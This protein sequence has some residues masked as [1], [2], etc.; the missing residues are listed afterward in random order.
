M[1]NPGLDE[2]QAEIKITRKISVTSDMHTTLMAESKG[3]KSLLMNVK[4]ESGK[5][6]LNS[7]SEK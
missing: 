2:T 5:V 6:G 1:Q 3:L 4:E 7:H